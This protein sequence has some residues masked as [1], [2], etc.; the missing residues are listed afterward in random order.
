[1][2][3]KFI[4]QVILLT[5]GLMCLGPFPEA[6]AQMLLN[7]PAPGL[8]IKTSYA[9]KPLE[10]KGI[11][12]YA[13]NPLRFDF[14]VDKGNSGLRGQALK[15]EITH[16]TKYF[17]TCLTVPEKDLWVNLSPYEKNRIAPESFGV[18]E[19]GKSLL[20]QD[21]LLK[22][23][24]ASLSYPE[25]SLGREFWQKVYQKAKEL[26]GTTNVPVGTF[27]KVWIVPQ[28]ASVYVR[29]N[30]AFVSHSKLEVMLEEDY[31]A[32]EN[33]KDKRNVSNSPQEAKA[34]APFAQIIR[35][36]ILPQLRQEVNEGKNFAVVRQVYSAMILATWYKRHLKDSLLGKT[37]VGKNKV[38]GVDVEDKDVK[39][40]IFQQYLKAYKKCVY[41]YIKEDY[42]PLTQTTA[43]RK[44]ASGGMDFVGFGGRGDK[45]YKESY[46]LE[47]LFLG[48]DLAMATVD[49]AAA[50]SQGEMVEF[51]DGRLF[52]NTHP[53]KAVVR[54]VKAQE[55]LGR[56]THLWNTALCDAVNSLGSAVVREVKAQESLGRFTHLWNT[57]LCDAVNSLGS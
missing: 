46:Q 57:A 39:E 33:N 8:M 3:R 55:S 36:V 4:I 41:N 10:L 52:P 5:F 7:L 37:Y 35:E 50:N 51:P 30:G 2:V 49:V 9:F 43:P 15:D 47:G 21:Y 6:K 44:Y 34:A 20:E 23:M 56:F 54:E 11:Q 16:L 28:S 29:G 32:F 17:L 12:V 24:M 22:Q 13:N 26:Y 27:N 25:N 42:D 31:T 53:L 1:M 45:V 19:M 40:K 48:N 14:L 18:T 38:T